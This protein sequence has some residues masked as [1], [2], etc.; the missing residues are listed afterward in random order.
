[1]AALPPNERGSVWRKWDFHV[2]TP[3]SY[4]WDGGKRFQDMSETEA[5]ASC[6][7]IIERMNEADAAAFVIMDYWTFDGYARLKDLPSMQS[8][9]QVSQGVVS[10]YRAALRGTHR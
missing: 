7:A 5:N 4:K 9:Y 10:R 2:H 3:A 8:K 1:M 6:Q